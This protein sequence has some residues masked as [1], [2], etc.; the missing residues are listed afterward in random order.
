MDAQC[1]RCQ[2]WVRI[3]AAPA[4]FRAGSHRRV[5]KATTGSLVVC[6]NCGEPGVLNRQGAL[7]RPLEFLE[8]VELRKD[9]KFWELLATIVAEVKARR[10]DRLGGASAI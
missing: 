2:T 10:L 8:L 7:I 3:S 9:E 4:I 1:L 6:P 5:R